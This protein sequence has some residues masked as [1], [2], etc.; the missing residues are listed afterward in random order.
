MTVKTHFRVAQ[1]SEQRVGLVEQR[2]T[3][4]RGPTDGF[5]SAQPILRATCGRLLAPPFRN[6][7][8]RSIEVLGAFVVV[9]DPIAIGRCLVNQFTPNVRT[10][11]PEMAVPKAQVPRF[12]FANERVVLLREIEARLHQSNDHRPRVGCKLL[13][14]PDPLSTPLTHLAPANP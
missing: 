4:R 13:V 6:R 2:E 14:T 9:E 5:R 8:A 12:F 10:F 3:H 1:I 11:Y 7:L